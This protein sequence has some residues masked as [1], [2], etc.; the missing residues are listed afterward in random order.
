MKQKYKLK[1]KCLGGE[2]LHQPIAN[3]AKHIPGGLEC[4]ALEFEGLES[5][6]LIRLIA[7]DLL[8]WPSWIGLVELHSLN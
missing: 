4:G 3:Q 8:D 7:L 2:S 6:G 5:T 1:Q